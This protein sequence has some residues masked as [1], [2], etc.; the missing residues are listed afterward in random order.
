MAGRATL[1]GAR[2]A[3][4]RWVFRALLDEGLQPWNKVRMVLA[5][6]SPEPTH[7]VDIDGYFEA[8]VASLREH[9]AYLE[10]FGENAPDPEEMLEGFARAAGSR[11]GVAMAATFEVYPLALL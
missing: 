2:D 9:R 8:G 6:G 10:A 7:A 3:G 11:L 1:D 4:N 5:A